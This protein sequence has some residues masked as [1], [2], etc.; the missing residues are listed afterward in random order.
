MYELEIETKNTWKRIVNPKKARVRDWLFV[1]VLQVMDGDGK[2]HK[3]CTKS[4][5]A[6]PHSVE[7][8]IND[9][10]KNRKKSIYID[11]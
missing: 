1:Q 7:R 4:L 8:K 6:Y 5:I 3:I 2:W 9:A 10:I 11:I